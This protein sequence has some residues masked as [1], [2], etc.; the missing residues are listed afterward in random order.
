MNWFNFT[1]TDPSQ[2]SHYTFTSGTPSCASPTQQMC[3]LQAD[4]DLGN[5]P[6]ITENLKD[7]IILA[8]Q[9]QANTTNV[10]LKKR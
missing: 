4:S 6:V 5:N 7:E 10:R 8:L 1:G 3:A 9:S 2:P